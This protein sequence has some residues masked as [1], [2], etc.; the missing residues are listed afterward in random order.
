MRKLIYC[1]SRS[2][3]L[4]V[5]VREPRFVLLSHNNLY[6]IQARSA[7]DSIIVIPRWIEL[8]PFNRC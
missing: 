7:I 3:E 4:Q 5:V 6:L 2:S 1:V 8:P